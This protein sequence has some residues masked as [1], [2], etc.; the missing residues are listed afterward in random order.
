MTIY[1]DVVLIENLIMNFIILLA[2]GI[3]LKE[4]IKIIRLLS[5]SLLGAIY[6]VVSYMSIL[7]IYSSIIL[8]VI[9]SI[10]IV[11]IAFNPQNMKKMWKDILLFYLTSFVFGGAAFALIYIV[12][13]QEILMKNGLFLGTYPLKTIVLGTIV[14]FTII[15]TA[16]TVVK[17]K[18][19]KK[20]MF[21][22]IEIELNGEKIETT[23][24]L[25]TGNLLKEPISNTP[26]IVVEHTLLYGCIPKEIL[27]HLDELLGGDFEKIPEEIKEK[28]ISKLKFIPFSSLGKQNGMLLGIKAESIIIKDTDKEEKKENIIVGIYNKP[29]T[30]RGEY[31][32]L[33]GIELL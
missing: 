1:I 32:A 16:F 24:M 23:A 25:D 21:C 33:I 3:I 13:P 17:S 9:L 11:Y 29:L 22:E 27:N 28:Y 31:R 20:D 8:K 30:K 19:T 26:V 7:E 15:I 4:K 2:T 14:A 10:L 6:S 5:A 12:K 18:I